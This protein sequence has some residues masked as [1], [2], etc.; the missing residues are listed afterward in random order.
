MARSGN[1]CQTVELH[2]EFDNDDSKAAVRADTSGQVRPTG[3]R[4]AGEEGQMDRRTFVIEAGKA[5][6]VVVG[7]LYA[8]GCTSSTT[9]PSAVADVASTSTI[10]NGHTH[11]ANVPA[12]DQLHPADTTYTSSN[13]LNHVHMVTLTAAQLSTIAS[14]RPVTVTSTSSAVTGDHT[15]DFTFQAKT[16]SAGQG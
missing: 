10:V 15:H 4:H 3:Q 14:G 11:S 7:A 13:A 12:S 6:P 9:S 1:P 5:F 16:L 8:I 2:Q